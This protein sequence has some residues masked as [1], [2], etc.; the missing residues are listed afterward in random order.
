MAT[1]L[2]WTTADLEAFPEPLDDTR[3]EIVDGQRRLVD[4]YRKEGPALRLAA[5][6][7]GHDRLESPLLPGFSVP[8][9]RLFLPDDM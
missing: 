2:R 1:I 4:V 3:Y 9:S 7:T 8:V 5:T 6:V